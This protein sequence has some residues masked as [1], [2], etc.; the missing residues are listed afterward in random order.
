MN[1]IDTPLLEL[2]TSEPSLDTSVKP[3]P[4]DSSESSVLIPGINKMID[5]NIS[6]KTRSVIIFDVET[7][8][9]LPKGKE[10]IQP[11]NSINLEDYPYITQLSFLVY[12]QD[13]AILRTSYNVYINIPQEIVISP[14]ITELT[15]VNREV[16]DKGVSIVEALVTFYNTYVCCDQIVAH[17]MEFDSRMIQI[18]LQRNKKE[19]IQRCPFIVGMFNFNYKYNARMI[20]T[21]RKS[22]QLCDIQRT[23]TRGLYK[24]F[25][26]LSEL[27]QKL[28]AGPL[29]ENLHNSLM[30]TLVCLRCYLE[31]NGL[32]MEEH[33]FDSYVRMLFSSM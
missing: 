21:M 31:L 5:R 17:N 30:D 13:M 26:K 9:L 22:I 28:F 24:K 4:S 18:E 15:G 25:P 8:G 3:E 14:F 29:P 16:C 20:C 7:T 6:L 1:C 12:D 32:H 23:N 33:V 11:V 27:Y 2:E 19:L 10:S